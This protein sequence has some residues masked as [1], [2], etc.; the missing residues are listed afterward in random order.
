MRRIPI[1]DRVAFNTLF[2]LQHFAPTNGRLI[3]SRARV[4]LRI[5][6][7]LR[8]GGP[9]RVVPVDRVT[10]LSPDEF[11]HRYLA[12]GLPVIFDRAAAAWP[13][14]R[15]WSF[16]AWKQRYARDTIKLAHHKG[17]SDHD[18]VYEREVSEE[19]NFGEFL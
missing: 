18:F 16:D 5:A 9:G 7:H 2:A 17:L 10:D 6:E 14:C 4:R 8:R 12:N 1:R 13:C 19:V 11:R 15:Q 3:Q